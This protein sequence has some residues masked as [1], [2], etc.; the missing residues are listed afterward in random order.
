MPVLAFQYSQANSQDT[1]LKLMYWNSQAEPENRR[2]HSIESLFHVELM[3]HYDWWVGYGTDDS[4]GSVV[5]WR[6]MLE[7]EIEFVIELGKIKIVHKI[8]KI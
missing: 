6:T 3:H 5:D 4:F 8:D 7:N 2:Y 1:V